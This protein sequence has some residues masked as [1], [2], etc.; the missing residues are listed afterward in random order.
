MRAFS[1]ERVCGHGGWAT[2]K[3]GK[4]HLRS[5]IEARPKG[6]RDLGRQIIGSTMICN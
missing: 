4:A 1:R 5:D 3:S 2:W 6:E